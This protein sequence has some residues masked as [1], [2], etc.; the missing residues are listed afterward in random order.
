MIKNV[1]ELRKINGVN[2]YYFESGIAMDKFVAQKNLDCHYT[3]RKVHYVV[4]STKQIKIVQE[5]GTV[6]TGYLFGEHLW[7]YDK[8]EITDYSVSWHKQDNEKRERNRILKEISL[9]LENYT[10][11][12]LIA[13]YE[14]I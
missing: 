7:S 13:L 2:G 11:E 6:K 5:N 3:T 9:K 4:S 10:K 12:E 14:K 8:E 1:K